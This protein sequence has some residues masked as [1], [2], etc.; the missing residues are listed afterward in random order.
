MAENTVVDIKEFKALERFKSLATGLFRRNA[1]AAMVGKTFLGNRDL[2]KELGYKRVLEFTDYNERYAR[3]GIAAKVVDAFASATWRNKPEILSPNN[4]FIDEFEKLAERIKLYHYFERIDRLAGVG[5]YGV[6]L[7]GARGSAIESPLNHVESAN[8]ILFLAPFTQGNADIMTLENDVT[9]NR[10]ALPKSY[11]LNMIRE[12]DNLVVKNF[13]TG[14]INAHYTRILHVAEGLM[15]DDIFGTP[16]MQKVWNYL[17]DLDKIAGASAEGVWKTVDRGIQ[18]DLDKDMDMDAD[19]EAAFADEIAEHFHG[20]KRYFKTKGITTTVLGSSIADPRGPFNVVISLISGT[21]GIPQRV[22]L[23]SER[24]ELASSQDERNFNG[25]VKERQQSYANPL[26]MRPFI[27]NLIRIGALPKPER[28]EIKWPDP[29]TLTEKEK[30]D[31]AARNAQSVRNVSGQAQGHMVMPPRMFAKLYFGLSEDD[32]VEWDKL[33]AE[34]KR[35]K[36]KK[37][38]KELAAKKP[39]QPKKVPGPTGTA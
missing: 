22:L 30:S 23:G 17:D 16:R 18:F 32:L 1:L 31:V 37:E 33:V 2:Y 38:K 13:P 12:T 4:E 6:L 11:R 10:F 27:D 9:S 14:Q 8:D 28:Y 39:A 7:M 34:D 35:E 26:M 25:R 36:E 20:Q 19:D 3:G 15:E 29:S 5:Q 24:G 21:T